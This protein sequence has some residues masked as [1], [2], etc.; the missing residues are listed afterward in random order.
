LISGIP[1]SIPT[2]EVK[3][4]TGGELKE[5]TLA[6]KAPEADLEKLCTDMKNIA[7]KAWVRFDDTEGRAD[8]ADGL[9]PSQWQDKQL[10]EKALP[11]I[12]S[13]LASKDF[14]R[15]NDNFFLA[16][17]K[18]FGINP[19]D[20]RGSCDLPKGTT[21]VKITLKV[22]ESKKTALTIS[23]EDMRY[24]DIV[25]LDGQLPAEKFENLI[26]ALENGKWDPSCG[27]MDK[28]YFAEILT[29]MEKRKSG[30]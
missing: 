7:A 9:T 15:F 14:N 28:A 27:I 21:E 25:Y 26:K 29:D 2:E 5:V 12:K 3:M 20:G 17:Y 1:K 24:I 11:F 4:R 13:H 16:V 8:P 19:G 22:E 30:K 23:E 6:L 18:A 10:I